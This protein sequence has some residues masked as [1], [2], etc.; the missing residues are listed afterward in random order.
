MGPVTAIA[1]L[2]APTLRLPSLHAR[3]APFLV[4]VELLA[5]TTSATFVPL[6][7]QSS[8]GRAVLVAVSLRGAATDC[9]QPATRLLQ[10]VDTAIVAIPSG[11]RMGR[12][13]VAR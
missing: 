6:L 3:H 2:P 5:S 8:C 12:A 4:L 9:W 1:R 11:V 7:R 10:R 13:G